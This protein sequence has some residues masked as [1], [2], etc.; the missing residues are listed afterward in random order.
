MAACS[1][2]IHENKTITD[3]I[4]ATANYVLK[5]NDAT[6]FKGEIRNNAFLATSNYEEDLSVMESIDFIHTTSPFYICRA[7]DQITFVYEV[8]STEFSK[9]STVTQINTHNLDKNKSVSLNINNTNWHLEKNKNIYF[10]KNYDTPVILD[11]KHTNGLHN[12]AKLSNSKASATL[13]YK[14]QTTL[15][16]ALFPELNSLST[17]WMFFDITAKPKEALFSGVLP[18]VEKSL[19][20]VFY[21]NSPQISETA[22]LVG[23]SNTHFTA[24]MFDNIDNRF[25][26][27]SI[28]SLTVATIS[29][30]GFIEKD[31]KI[32]ATALF[33]SLPDNLLSYYASSQLEDYKNTAIYQMEA[34]SQLITLKEFTE[35]SFEANYFCSG[36]NYLLFTNTLEELQSQLDDILNENVLSEKEYYTSTL[37]KLPSASSILS[38]SIPNETIFKS[39]KNTKGLAVLQA[40]K[41][42]KGFYAT[43]IC[44]ETTL[45]SPQV[46]NQ[47]ITEAGTFKLDSDMATNPILVKNYITNSLDVVVQDVSN[48]LYLISQ[49]GKI[50]WKR[51]LDSKIQGEITQ[52]DMYNNGKLQLAFTT[53]HNFYIVTRTGKDAPNFPIH[54]NDEFSNPVAIF[55]YDLKNDYRFLI[56]QK[57]R[58]YMLSNNG[59]RVKGFKLSKTRGNIIATP[60]HIRVGK[61][62][63]LIVKT[64]KDKLYILDR[65]GQIRIPVSTAI[66]FSD[67]EMFWNKGYFTT[68]NTKGNIIRVTEKGDV[69]EDA[70][71]LALNHAITATQETLVTF[72]ENLLT[73]GAYPLVL[74]YGVYTN[75]K[76]YNLPKKT[77]ITLTDT[78]GNK[79]YAYT[80]KGELLNGF[81]IFGK[82]EAYLKYNP[83][84]K[85]T[86]LV[87]K[88][89]NNE[90]IVYTF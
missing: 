31:N 14:E 55:D 10:L 33:T 68:T 35:K 59:K 46:T 76:I 8:T 82:E 63:Y 1:D 65:R 61:K 5:V 60:Q 3:Y 87:V 24:F 41:S 79:V 86:Y 26:P 38:V 30:I 4:P 21:N 57:N 34:D 80:T 47:A 37:E 27:S 9:D 36:T 56:T 84:D 52:I 83:N 89:A 16:T 70:A 20:S 32:T 25:F 18:T 77:V 6:S 39:S 40:T 66:Q 49:G 51:K 48:N 45:T 90:L 23:A 29:E 53:K 54:F 78:Q 17:D 58:L 67:N 42:T 28:D 73:I 43:A 2:S 7:N 72:T 85:L 15:L 88:A 11:D 12:I 74:D 75:P 22:Q 71:P 19:D 81:P 64:D 50:Q 13:F 44:T 69:S 62:D